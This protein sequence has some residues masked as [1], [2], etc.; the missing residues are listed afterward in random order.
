MKLKRPPTTKTSS[1]REHGIVYGYRSGLEEKIAQEL[2]EAGVDFEYEEHVIR[3]IKP[4][5]PAR[6]TPDFV[7]PNGIIIETKGRFL[8]PDRQK[9]ILIKQQ[10]PSLDIRF[11]FS[12]SKERIGKK[13]KTTYA[14]WCAKNGFPF[15]DVSIPR[16]WLLEP[17]RPCALIDG[18]S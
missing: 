11:V 1:K 3:F 6:Y 4:T 7:L 15:A 8:T 18:D 17:K 9:M 10:H 5:K 13:S 2:L 14:M 12:R 16:A